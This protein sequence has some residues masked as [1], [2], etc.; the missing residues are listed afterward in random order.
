[1][2]SIIAAVGKN[3]ELGYKGGLIWHLPNDLKFFKQTT[4]GKTIV[5]GENT[6]KSLKGILPNRHHVVLSENTDFPDEV[7]VFASLED[8]LH[9]YKKVKDEVFI[10]GGA[11]VYSEF[12]DLCE[13]MYLTEVDDEFKDATVYF[14]K[15]NK[16]EWD[17]EVLAENSDNNINYKH[18]LYKRKKGI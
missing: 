5:M 9:K 8:F 17:S 10:I 1:M 13:R 15:F 18:V 2:F 14:P 16:S 3:N 6:F 11:M 12:I 7:E 4:T